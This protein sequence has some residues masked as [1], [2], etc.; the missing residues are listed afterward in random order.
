M[1]RSFNRFI[2]QCRDRVDTRELGVAATAP[3][4]GHPF[5]SR[6]TGH[7]GQPI[8]ALEQ[9]RPQR[10]RPAL[11]RLSGCPRFH[12]A[13]GDRKPLESGIPDSSLLL[14][15][16][17]QIPIT[18]QH[19]HSMIPLHTPFCTTSRPSGPIDSP[20]LRNEN[21]GQD[22]MRRFVRHRHPRPAIHHPDLGG[23]HTQSTH[24]RSLTSDHYIYRR[25]SRLKSKPLSH[26]HPALG[27]HS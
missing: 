11:N 18:A 15:Q 2:S 17:A 4:L 9:G 27:T 26:H 6:C 13:A 23:H 19:R 10:L 3:G 14:L 8:R 20:S 25:S 16:I 24:I 7:R 22:A 1:Q 5:N 12:A 21:P